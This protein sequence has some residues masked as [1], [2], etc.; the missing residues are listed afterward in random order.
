MCKLKSSFTFM[1]ELIHYIS[2]SHSIPHNAVLTVESEHR[3]HGS[4]H[5]QSIC[6]LLSA[7]GFAW[8]F[9]NGTIK[10]LFHNLMK[11]MDGTGAWRI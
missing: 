8:L 6:P 4:L 3:S 7:W 5:L 9:A 1:G 10:E 11:A 2:G